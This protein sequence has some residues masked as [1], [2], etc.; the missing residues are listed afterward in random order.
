MKLKQDVSEEKLNGRYFTPQKI[1]DYIT[2]WVM[3]QN[4]PVTLILEPSVGDGVFIKSVLNSPYIDNTTRLTSIEIDEEV[5]KEAALSG[6]NIFWTKGWRNAGQ[7]RIMVINDDFYVA[8][9]NGLAQQKFDAVLGNPPYIRYQYLDENQRNEQSEILIKNGM[10]SNKLINAWVSFTV[11]CVSCMAADSRIGFVIPAELLQ[12]KYSEDLRKFLTG[13]LNKI[14][15][16]TFRN[17]VFEGIE[18]EVVLFLGEKINGSSEHDIRII[19][20]EDLIQME[21]SSLDEYEFFTADLKSSKWTK[22]FLNNLE[23]EQVQLAEQDSRFVRFSKIAKCEVGITT[24]NNEYFCVDASKVQQYQLHNYCKPLIARSVNIQ[25]AEFTQT[26][27]EKNIEDGARTYLLDLTPFDK[28]EFNDG[29]R[30]YIDFGVEGKYNS[31]YKCQIRDEWYKV[32]SVWVPDAFF[33]RRNYLYPKFML[34]TDMVKAVSTDTMHRVRFKK[35]EFRKRAVVGYYTSIGLLFSE[36][37]GRSYGGGVLEILPG[38]VGKVLLPNIFDRKCISD[39]EVERLFLKIDQHIRN[40][41]DIIDL[42]KIMDTEI[43]IGKLNFTE[44]QVDL[45]RSAWINLR[46]R[47][48]VRGG[49]EATNL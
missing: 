40:N 11:A 29:V 37:E 49:R 45:F 17:L 23:L 41:T 24:G 7:N 46:N 34:N 25:G 9:K 47:R 28:T 26:D 12:V 39:E 33:L 22:Y 19:Q 16:I 43:L 14:T 21:D 1:A 38:E 36:L 44:T 5:S 31:T 8:Y 13:H 48:L 3:I 2:E 15:V 4:K 30:Q 6:K 35:N 18:Q 42:L 27:W 20:F 32:P 10:K